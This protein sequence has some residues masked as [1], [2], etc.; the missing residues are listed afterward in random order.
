MNL[1]PSM[2]DPDV[3]GFGKGLD[4]GN[5]SDIEELGVRREF[6]EPDHRAGRGKFTETRVAT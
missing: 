5:V 4:K 2:V 6:F 3:I 1:F